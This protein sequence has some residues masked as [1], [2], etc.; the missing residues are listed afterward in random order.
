[1]PKTSPKNTTPSGKEDTKWEG[2]EEKKRECLG[3]D[4]Q[5]LILW[6]DTDVVREKF[7]RDW[8][9]I[10]KRRSFAFSV[11]GTVHEQQLRR[12]M[13]HM[14]R[15]KRRSDFGLRSWASSLFPFLSECT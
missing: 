14:T 10:S 15:T 1:M 3:E 11:T 2:F 9:A 6:N 4:K 5:V 13:A 12:T 7:D 8:T